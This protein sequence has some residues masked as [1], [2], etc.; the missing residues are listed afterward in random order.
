MELLELID[1]L[2]ELVHNARPVPL[3]DQVRVDK[4]EVYA[5]VDRMRAVLPE[6]IRRLREGHTGAGEQDSIVAAVTSAVESVLRENIPAIAQA[7]AAAARGA[8]GPS[9]PPG[10]PF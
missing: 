4:D 5:I 9:P 8:T 2:D 3:T 6:D 1:R 7:A 10:G